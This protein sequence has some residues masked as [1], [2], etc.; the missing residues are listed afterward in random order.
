MRGCGPR[1][2]GG[3]TPSMSI[4]KLPSRNKGFAL[5]ATPEGR[6]L[7]RSKRILASVEHELLEYG[8]IH[9]FRV[10]RDESRGGYNVTVNLEAQSMRYRRTTFL[11]EEE[12]MYLR[13]NPALSD[14]LKAGAWRM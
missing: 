7:L 2:V 12:F 11:N 4:G 1:P 3:K 5:Y 10:E 13:S 14:L 8:R 9:G 6:R